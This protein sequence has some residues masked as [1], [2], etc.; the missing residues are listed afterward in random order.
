MSRQC[1]C[2]FCPIEEYNKG[3]KNVI[4]I[5]LNHKDK[6]M[7]MS[8]SNDDL[9]IEIKKA[10]ET[11]MFFARNNHNLKKGETLPITEK[12]IHITC[13]SKSYMKELKSTREVFSVCYH[14]H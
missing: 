12:N 13:I 7:L 6:D 14:P 8:M 4:T 2:P 9:P 11:L 3:F 10:C 1:D 5:Y